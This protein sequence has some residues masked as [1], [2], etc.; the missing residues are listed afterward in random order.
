M[1]RGICNATIT[2]AEI[3][4]ERGFALVVN[5]GLDYG[6]SHQ[7]FGGYVL[8]HMDRKPTAHLDAWLT[9]IF[10]TFEIERFSDLKGKPCR[11]DADHGRVYR[12]GNFL[13]D[14]WIDPEE[15]NEAL[16]REPF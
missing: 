3:L 4:L 6:S 15:I 1:E 2:S 9:A 5:I 13:K 11:A 7:T 16:K 10:K 12:I 14:K 8:G